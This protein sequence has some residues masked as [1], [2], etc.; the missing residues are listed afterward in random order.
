MV[1]CGRG[2]GNAAG[3]FVAR[4]AD[5]AHYQGI[6]QILL[7]T[8]AALTGGALILLPA[9]LLPVDPRWGW[10]LVPIALLTNGFWALHH[11]AIHNGFHDDPRVN[12]FA[13]RLMAILL[14]SSF[15]VLRF[16]HLMHHRHNRNPIDR[17]DT[18]DPA[19]APRLRARLGFLFNLT[20]GLYLVEVA[21]PL[22]CLLPRRIVGR[23][24][25]RVYRGEDAALCAIRQSAL[26]LFL[27]RRKLATI[28]ADA[29]MAS[30]LVAVSAL[31]FAEHWPMLAAFL[32]ARGALI[33][34]FD[35]VYHFATPIDRP[36]YARNLWLPAPLRLLVLNMNLH[37]VHHARPGLPWWD[38]PREMRAR[39]DRF[40]AN[41][42]RQALAQFAGPV[43]VDTLV[44]AAADRPETH[45]AA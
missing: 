39:G 9:L 31:L 22:V 35:N 3:R 25:E 13:G 4:G 29:L 20:C 44:S 38:L 12:R 42:L 23:I 45:E 7:G 43:A 28:R 30:G 14:G 5:A 40:D 11:E 6:N 33:S 10:L 16:G 19:Q 34:V 17:P 1:K 27:D 18:Y 41:L 37:R 24:V 32:L 2:S 15:A 26:R 8:M 36:D 21:V